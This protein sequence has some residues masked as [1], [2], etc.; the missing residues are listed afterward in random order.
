MA[1][2]FNHPTLPKINLMLITKLIC[3]QWKFQ[4]PDQLAWPSK[5]CTLKL[6]FFFDHW[7]NHLFQSNQLF[8]VIEFVD[9]PVPVKVDI[10]RSFLFLC[11]AFVISPVSMV[12]AKNAWGP[13]S[14]FEHTNTH[15]THKKKC[16]QF[17]SLAAKAS[18]TITRKIP[19]SRIDVD[20]LFHLTHSFYEW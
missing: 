7:S 13:Q 12:S 15:M 10:F 17:K 18:K 14:H 16:L 2:H 9:Q 5:F 4:T 8:Q 6:F 3:K 1:H 19:G 11:M 20:T